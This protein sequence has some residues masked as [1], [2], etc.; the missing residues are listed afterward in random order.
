MRL[1]ALLAALFVASVGDAQTV[2][3][4]ARETL[5]YAV[6]WR[7]VTAGKARLDW[8]AA[9]GGR[10]WES[11][12]HIESVGLVSKLFKVEDDYFAQLNQALCVQSSQMSTREGVRQRETR[13]TFDGNTRKAAYLEIDKIHN[14][15][16]LSQE[17]DIPPCVHDI[18]GG[19]YYLR[20]LNLEPGQAVQSPVSDGKKVVSARVE[21]QQREDVKTPAGSFK[22]IRYE[23]YLFNNVLWKRSGHLLIW[24]TDD[25]RRIPVQIRV[26]LPFTIGTITLQLEKVE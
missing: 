4:P 19:I 10:G 20:T 7:L 18:V 5:S 17:I 24:V 21:A 9:A 8:T 26:R 16:V 6:E 22:T 25:R 2:N 3:L 14:T 13:I 23:I 11:R 1:L 12:V 15:T